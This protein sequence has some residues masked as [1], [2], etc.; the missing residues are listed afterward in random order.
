MPRSPHSLEAFAHQIGHDFA[1]IGILRLALM[2]PSL[3]LDARNERLEFL[4]DR[5]LGLVLVQ[6]L[7]EEFP[8]DTEGQLAR[9]LAFLGSGDVCAQV[10]AKFDL[11][12]IFKALSAKSID[13]TPRVAANCCESIIAAIYMD[14][15]LAAAAAFVTTHWHG[16]LGQAEPID[17]KTR[18]QEYLA[19]RKAA[20]PVYE[21][22][23]QSGPT[24][25]P[26]FDV[27][28]SVAGVGVASARAGARQKAEQKAAKSW[29]AEFADLKS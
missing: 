6:W 13:V 19:K 27:Q 7:M 24:H 10:M 23:A 8:E 29:L 21:I 2:H 20:L 11:P 14:A 17:A 1:D 16:F 3:E 5:V 25:A 15:G 9:R 22:I 4:G 28:V 18:L 12:S 26:V